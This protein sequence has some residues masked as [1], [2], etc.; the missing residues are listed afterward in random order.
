VK[1]FADFAKI[2]KD[3]VCRFFRCFKILHDKIIFAF[4]IEIWVKIKKEKFKRLR[5]A[6]FR[7]NAESQC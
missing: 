1:L 4:L 6:N 5:E 2:K 7:D 3:F